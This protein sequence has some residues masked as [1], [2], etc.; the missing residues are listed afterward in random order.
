MTDQDQNET[1]KSDKSQDEAP[2]QDWNK[3]AQEAL[4][5][6]QNHLTSLANDAAAKDEMARFVAPM[7]Q[8]FSSW[9]TMMQLGLASVMPQEPAQETGDDSTAAEAPAASSS[10]QKP[11]AEETSAPMA[12]QPVTP[13]A[14][15]TA[16]PDAPPYTPAKEEG[17]RLAATSQPAPSTEPTTKPEPIVTPASTAAPLTASGALGGA[18][19]PRPEPRPRPRASAADG[20]G[21]LA[22]LA[23]RLAKLER[24][25]ETLRTRPKR[26]A[27]DVGALASENADAQ[28]PAAGNVQRVV[29]SGST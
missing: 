12:A 18:A 19:E 17:E 23:S 27:G 21:D 22:E 1:P 14:A 13:A 7:S 11:K 3:L 15:K 9:T 26:H 6:W 2:R 20:T 4:D 16:F 8:M 29:G 24:E 5:L 28:A 10:E 25:L